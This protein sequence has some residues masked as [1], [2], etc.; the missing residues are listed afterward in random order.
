MKNQTENLKK[1]I[2]EY[3][4]SKYSYMLT[5]RTEEYHYYDPRES[6]GHNFHTVVIK[7]SI[8]I[9]DIIKQ[10][11][12]AIEEIEQDNTLEYLEEDNQRG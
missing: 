9:G 8:T 7:P 3:Y 1:A 2:Y 10:A 6:D 12:I 11:E 4:L 5:E